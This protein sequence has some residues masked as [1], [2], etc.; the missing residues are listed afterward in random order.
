M[1]DIQLIQFIRFFF[2]IKCNHCQTES[3][4]FVSISMNE[5]FELP[6]GRGGKIQNNSI[7]E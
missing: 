6:T 2:K 4:K 3:E 1:M 5:K 7:K